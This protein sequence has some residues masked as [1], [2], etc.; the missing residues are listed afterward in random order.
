MVDKKT[1]AIAVLCVITVLCLGLWSNSAQEIQRLKDRYESLGS[2]EEYESQI[3]ILKDQNDEKDILII[4]LQD[5]VADLESQIDR[6][7][8]TP[9]VSNATWRLVW[10][11]KADYEI[12]KVS[13]SSDGEYIA[14]IGDN[15]EGS[16]NDILHLL[17]KDRKLLWKKDSRELLASSGWIHDVS[18]S[19]NASFIVVGSDY[20]SYLLQRDGSN[21]WKVGN[22]SY[23]KGMNFVSISDDGE[24]VV[25]GT[26]PIGEGW[27]YLFDNNGQEIWNYRTL[28]SVTSVAISDKGEYAIAGDTKGYVYLFDRQGNLLWDKKMGEQYIKSIHVSISPDG[29]FIGVGCESQDRVGLSNKKGEWMLE[30]MGVKHLVEGVSITSTGDF[31]FIPAGESGLQIYNAEGTFIESFESRERVLDVANTPDGSYLVVGSDDM[32]VYLLKK[33]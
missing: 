23:L 1:V 24:Y 4:D 12:K 11:Y 21:L 15:W 8:S 32:R 26:Y 13:I 9:P 10:E 29:Q 28:G 18:V 17:T 30:P 25:I 16:R 14:A 2:I 20:G 22:Y 33:P 27:I 7:T 19:Q 6:L 5:R 31:L 3:D